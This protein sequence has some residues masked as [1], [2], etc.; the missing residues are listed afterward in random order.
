M[1]KFMLE[2]KSVPVSISYAPG[3]AVKATSGLKTGLP[4][5]LYIVN[6]AGET[7]MR[8][9]RGK[10]ILITLLCEILTAR[11]LICS[12]TRLFSHA[13]S[14]PDAWRNR[15]GAGTTPYIELAVRIFKLESRYSDMHS[16]FCWLLYPSLNHWPAFWLGTRYCRL[17]CRETRSTQPRGRHKRMHSRY[18]DRDLSIDWWK[19]Y[20]S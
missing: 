8:E 11:R 18:F 4:S 1:R 13:Y 2:V 10:G 17:S 6:V 9:I 3:S 12:K 16:R 5:L 20:C 7:L 19:R 14:H 15:F